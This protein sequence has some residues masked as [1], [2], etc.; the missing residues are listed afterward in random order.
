M[1]I[2]KILNNNLIISV[3]EDGKEIIAMGCGIAFGKKNGD[4]VLKNKVEK[5]FVL[6]D[7]ITTNKFERFL[8]E[9]P[10]EYITIADKIIKYSEKKFERKFNDL[11]CLSIADHIFNSCERF[12]NEKVI[13]NALLWDIKRFYKDEFEVGLYAIDIIDKELGIKFPEDEAAFIATHIVNARIN[14]EIP[15]VMNIIRTI[16]E[17]MSII[18]YNFKIELKEDDISYYRFITHLKF[19]IQRLLSGKA[20]EEQS[21]DEVYYII[22]N[23]YKNSTSCV[24][25]ISDYIKVKYKY[26]ISNQ[27]KLYLILHI[28]R[29]IKKLI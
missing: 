14:E 20:Y 4:I 9:I 3:N 19:F 16:Q 5:I 1:R 22:K 10:L 23:K 13:N 11:L 7:E 15:V 26:E 18:K 6:E 24:E 29:L 12:K 8:S 28:E 21:D 25:K 27:E 17:I 2:K